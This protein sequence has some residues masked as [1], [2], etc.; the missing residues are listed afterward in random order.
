MRKSYPDYKKN[1]LS[2]E[3]PICYEF[4]GR[5]H[6]VDDCGNKKNRYKS[7][8]KAIVATWDDKSKT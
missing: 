1:D 2:K 8:G 5:K 7:K 3:P 6:I 4:K